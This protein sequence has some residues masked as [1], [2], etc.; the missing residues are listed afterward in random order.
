MVSTTG[1]ST[2][3]ARVVDVVELV[4]V[5]G[6][7]V[8]ATAVVVVD[9]IGAKVSVVA[10]SAAGA[11]EQ[12][13]AMRETSASRIISRFMSG[14]VPPKHRYLHLYRIPFSDPRTTP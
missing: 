8:V 9:S 14:I 1:G 7:T 3:G 10:V 12:A 4:L 6:A 5:S 11:L 13:A 2:T